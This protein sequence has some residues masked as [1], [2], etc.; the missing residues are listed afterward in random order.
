MAESLSSASPGG[1]VCIFLRRNDG[2]DATRQRADQALK[3][4]YFYWCFPF[5]GANIGLLREH[6][7]EEKVFW[8]E[9]IRIG[10]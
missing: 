9:I 2:S 10:F 3:V 7:R 4:Q 1:G 5:T 6:T 8:S